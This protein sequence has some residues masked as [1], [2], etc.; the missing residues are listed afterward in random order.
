LEQWKIE[1]FETT[2]TEVLREWLPPNIS[3]QV[4]KSVFG[5]TLEIK[6]QNRSTLP[7]FLQKNL[8]QRFLNLKTY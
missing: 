5:E 6:M 7:T 8:N 4:L 2:F 1:V 3:D